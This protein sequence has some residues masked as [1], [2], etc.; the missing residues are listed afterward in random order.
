MANRV[1]APYGTGFGEREERG[2][3]KAC[4]TQRR[5]ARSRFGGNIFTPVAIARLDRPV[6]E[7]A[8]DVVHY[9]AKR[10]SVAPR[11]LPFLLTFA[12]RHPHIYTQKGLS[13][14]GN[15]RQVDGH[16]E[17]CGCM[18]LFAFIFA[19]RLRLKNNKMHSELDSAR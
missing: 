9:R 7:C 8:L 11:A 13:R 6:R 10:K 4:P 12:I 14:V 17:L 5:R 3:R 15:L 18:T 1:K 16:V 19:P 2:I